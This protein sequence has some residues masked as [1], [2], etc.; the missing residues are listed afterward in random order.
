[1]IYFLAMSSIRE[2][3]SPFDYAELMKD[4]GDTQEWSIVL[5]EENNLEKARAICAECRLKKSRDGE[6]DMH[7]ADIG[8]ICVGI[9]RRG[10]T[11]VRGRV[12]Q[13][14]KYAGCGL[15]TGWQG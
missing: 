13:I 2:L 3:E 7:W 11:T 15:R 1:M 14:D 10:Y 4:G 12:G 8:A 6:K 9:N 5:G